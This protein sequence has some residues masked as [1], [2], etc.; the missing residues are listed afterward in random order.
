MSITMDELLHGN[1]PLSKH[2]QEIQDNLQ[3]LL[4][5]INKIR[6]AY[7]KVMVVTSGLRLAGNQPANAAA[8]SLHLLGLAVDVRDTDGSL[9]NWVIANLQLMKDLGVYIENFEWTRDPVLGYW[10]H[11]GIKAPASKKRIFVPSQAP[12]SSP[13]CWSGTYDKKY[14]LVNLIYS[15]DRPTL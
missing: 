14:D 1:G 3:K 7:G 15:T 6:D 4:V 8:K 10:V 11:F 9:M 13:G 2:S 12:A 5:I